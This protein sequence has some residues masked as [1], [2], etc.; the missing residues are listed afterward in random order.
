MLVVVVVHTLSP[1]A[2]CGTVFSSRP[3]GSG[4][5]GVRRLLARTPYGARPGFHRPT[6]RFAAGLLES[7]A[8][9]ATGFTLALALVVLVMLHV[10]SLCSPYPPCGTTD[11]K[12]HTAPQTA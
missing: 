10:L 9:F 8:A 2:R 11:H 7:Y 4:G 12:C 5:A 1:R 3:V 6:L